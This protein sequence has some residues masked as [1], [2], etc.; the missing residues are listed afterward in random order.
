MAATDLFFDL[1][2]KSDFMKKFYPFLLVSLI[3]FLAACRKDNTGR[4]TNLS[5]STSSYSGEYVR[6]YF[7][8]MCT[9][10]RSAKGFFPTQAVR[11]YGLD[12]TANGG[13]GSLQYIFNY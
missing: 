6:N 5:A 12:R 1:L 7:A 9:I 10:T 8:L 3:L 11:A 2:C 4:R 13:R